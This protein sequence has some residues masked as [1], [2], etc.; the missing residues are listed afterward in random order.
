MPPPPP[1]SPPQPPLPTPPPPVS[2]DACN[3]TLTVAPF[4]PVYPGDKSR[5]DNVVFLSANS[6]SWPCVL[7]MSNAPC[8]NANQC[9]RTEGVLF[10]HC[11]RQPD[12]ESHHQSCECKLDLWSRWIY[13]A[14][15]IRCPHLPAVPSVSVLFKSLLNMAL[16][17]TQN[18]RQPTAHPIQ[19]CANLVAGASRT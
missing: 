6:L 18:M 5:P 8:I 4:G 11:R 7:S 17:G 1:I 3:T 12:S 15:F 14:K 19:A 9:K 13:A 10:R 16:R 2:K